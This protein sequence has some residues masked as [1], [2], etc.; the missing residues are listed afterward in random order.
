MKRILALSLL[1]V[2]CLLCLLSCEGCNPTDDRILPPAEASVTYIGAVL[3]ASRPTK[4]VANV[5]YTL[6][7]GTTLTGRS[8]LQ[9][10]EVSGV[11]RAKF[12][13]EYQVL[14]PADAE[15]MIETVSNTVYSS[16]N[17]IA[18]FLPTGGYQFEAYTAQTTLADLH[19][20]EGA[21][22]SET[23]GTYRLV[24]TVAKADAD[25]TFGVTTGSVGDITLT[26]SVRD[27]TVISA[28]VKYD[29]ARGAMTVVTAYTYDEETFSFSKP[30]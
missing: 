29:T 23:D 14:A 24:M 6:T 27:D 11:V 2:T 15:E 20:P 30:E 25:T 28:E 8:T 16:G 22:V 9:V 4:A 21:S 18:N 10:Q 3:Q 1:F 12:A 7:D 19:L 17:R 26:L 5:T 13:Y